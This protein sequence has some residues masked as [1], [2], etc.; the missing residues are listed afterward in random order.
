MLLKPL[1]T[2]CLVKYE[3]VSKTE[4][5]IKKTK[6]ILT[7]KAISN[8]KNKRKKK[9]V[10]KVLL[11]ALVFSYNKAYCLETSEQATPANEI[12]YLDKILTAS[13]QFDPIPCLLK[14]YS[15][16]QIENSKT[17]EMLNSRPVILAT[18]RNS[19]LSS[20]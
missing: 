3:L 6:N 5:S 20:S 18:V 16:R 4:L 8:E 2:I 17:K 10:E 7:S 15:L 14:R 1:Q 12:A 11:L 13:L 9:N 19:N